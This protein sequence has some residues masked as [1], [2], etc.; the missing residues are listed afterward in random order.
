MRL[1]RLSSVY[2]ICADNNF[3]YIIRN[4]IT[5]DSFLLKDKE[6]RQL[7]KDIDKKNKSK[8]IEEL[9]KTHIV[10]P[11]DYSE[12]KFIRFIKEEHNLDNPKISIFYLT[13]NNECNLGCKYCYVEGS[14]S[15]NKKQLTM[16]PETFQQTMKF[17]KKFLKEG[18]KQKKL[19]EK[20]TFIYYGSEPLLNPGYIKESIKEIDKITKELK[21]EKSIQVITN[22]IL[23]T[24]DLIKIFKEY[25][26]E[27]AISLDGSKEI[28]NNMRVFKGTQK[29]TYD[30]IEKAIK[31]VIDAGISCGISCTIGPH[32]INYLKENIKLFKKMGSGGVGFNLL[33][34]AK[35][36]K[37]P[38]VSIN[39][40][41]DKLIEASK[42][43]NKLKL[44]EDRIQR[45]VK[46][47]NKSSC[48]QFKDCGAP[49]NQLVF[50][51]EGD[52]GV[53]QAYLGCER[54][55]LGN[56]FKDFDKPLSI[57]KKDVM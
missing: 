52:I 48:P 53:C 46:A 26:V 25:K 45:K 3:Y 51:P 24:D 19:T 42:L 39:K 55:L 11:E 38:Y 30:L 4:N 31:K 9:K 2:E 29:G 6:F 8:T 23:I 10:V 43:A 15:D 57:L 41:N 28:N 37:L 34:K 32:N 21:I 35:N 7:K 5:N 12:E 50:Y 56:I 13:F 40:S 16:A 27:L 47:F 49:G 17:L 18:K 44:Y 22:G 36:T 14:Y 20:L 1:S 54:P 33:L